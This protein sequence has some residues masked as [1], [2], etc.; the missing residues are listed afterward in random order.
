MARVIATER[1]HDGTSLREV[2]EEF[3]IPDARLKD[4]S[5]WFVLVDKRPAP[6]AEEPNAQPPGAG[7]KKG[8]RA[9]AEPEGDLA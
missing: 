7:P 8:S 2:G 1:G 6:K 3:D 4:G 5:T 9:K